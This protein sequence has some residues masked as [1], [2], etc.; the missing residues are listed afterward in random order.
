LLYYH[1]AAWHH[2]QAIHTAGIGFELLL[3]ARRNIQ[4]FF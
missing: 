2:A 3:D 1:E 4:T